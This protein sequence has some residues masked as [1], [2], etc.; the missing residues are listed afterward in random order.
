MVT[1]AEMSS[2]LTRGQRREILDKFRHGDTQVGGTF[3]LT[4]QP[5]YDVSAGVN[6][7]VCE[8]G[9]CNDLP[10]AADLV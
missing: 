2:S 1:V 3:F 4:S 10:I 6:R 5:Q 8:A 7:P 9:I